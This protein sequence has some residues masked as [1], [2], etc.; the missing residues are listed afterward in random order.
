MGPKF[1][2]SGLRGLVSE[3]TDTLVE[4]YVHAFL[5]TVQ[6]NALYV[7]QDLRPSSPRIAKTICDT[8]K[9]A[10]VDVIDCG[11]V[12]SPA[13]ALASM[14]A[15][16][17]AIMVTGSHIPADRNGLKF[18]L[19]D[20][21]I[22][23]ADEGA[24][25]TAYKER[26]RFQA[27]GGQG[28]YTPLPEAETR[29]ITRYL[30]AFGS[31]ALKGLKI[32]VYRHSSVARDTMEAI[33]RGLGAEVVPLAHSDTFV[34]VDTEA[35]DP[36]VRVKLR[37]WCLEH[38]FDA[39]ASTDG[40]ADRPMLTDGAGKVI[41]GDILGVLTARH[42]GA[43]SVI[44]PVSSN[45]MVRRLPEFDEVILT[46]IG[47]PFVIEGMQRAAHSEVVGFEANGGFLLGFS[48]QLRSALSPLPTRDAMLPIIAPLVAAQAA[49]Q[50]LSDLISSLPSWFTAADR[51]QDI[52]RDKAADFLDG[53]TSDAARR[54]AFFAPYGSIA[55][56]DHTDGLRVDFENGD[57]LHL[58][59]S[60][61]APEFR[62]YAQAKTETSAVELVEMACKDVAAMVL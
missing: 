24:I 55:T 16:A 6:S 38:G 62:V 45:D 49:G 57:V 50:S 8:A 60:G 9:A 31:D 40:D 58:R 34:P 10:G 59:P 20:G 17:P 33:L 43:K 30:G 7:G 48:A 52:N 12:G 61:N 3:L 25:S 29:Y 14:S 13:L 23:K 46:K 35:V 54:N 22:L 47:S 39:I 41:P 56:T 21:E 28:S 42:M 15:K 44:T 32:G 26:R 51:I 37:E 2:T 36:E 19:P 18:Y 5:C 27:L 1:G 53:I 11:A 4:D